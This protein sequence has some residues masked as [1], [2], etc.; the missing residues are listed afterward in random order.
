MKPTC[1]DDVAAYF[2]VRRCRALSAPSP[3]SFSLFLCLSLSLSVS[4]SLSLS[5]S[6]TLCSPNNW[7]IQAMW[8][9]MNLIPGLRTPTRGLML[10][11]N[12][13]SISHAPV[14][15]VLRSLPSRW[16]RQWLRPYRPI[17]RSHASMSTVILSMIIRDEGQRY[18]ITIRLRRVMFRPPL[19]SARFKLSVISG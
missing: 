8:D 6:Q 15:G 2:S 11:H 7:E 4:L 14:C 10:L 19:R 12:I 3:F 5:L 1:S 18:T 13:I 17:K 16:N 9:Q